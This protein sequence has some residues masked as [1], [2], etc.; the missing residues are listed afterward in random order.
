MSETIEELFRRWCQ[1][2]RLASRP[3]IDEE[4]EPHLAEYQALQAQIAGSVPGWAR[5]LAIMLLVGTDRWSSYVE[6]KLRA[7]VVTL[8]EERQQ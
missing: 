5:E 6:P 1:A 3:V 4:A 7:L 8:A 2:E